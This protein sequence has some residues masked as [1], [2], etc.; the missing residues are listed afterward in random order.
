MV[1]KIKKWNLGHWDKGHYVST[2]NRGYWSK[3]GGG[4][5][6]REPEEKTWYC[7]SCNQ[8]QLSVMPSYKIPLN[9]SEFAR[10]CPMCKHISLI[11]ELIYFSELVNLIRPYGNAIANLL[12][13][14]LR[15]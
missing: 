7:Q 14:P 13:L 5:H 12:S 3:Y 8:E 1:N 11:E 2:G 6:W 10:V 9:D 15:Y 4:D